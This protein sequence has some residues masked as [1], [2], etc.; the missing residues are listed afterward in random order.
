MTLEVE[1]K[2]EIRAAAPTTL[3]PDYP[4]AVMGLLPGDGDALVVI[5]CGLM[6]QRGFFTRDTH[7]SIGKVELAGRLLHRSRV[8]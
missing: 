7:S 2:P 3:P 8:E 5:S 1:I 6:R 4:P